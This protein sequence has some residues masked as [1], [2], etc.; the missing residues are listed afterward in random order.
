MIN[1]TQSNVILCYDYL[2]GT[3]IIYIINYL[4]YYVQKGS[5]LHLQIFGIQ[6]LFK[7][8]IHKAMIFK[9]YLHVES[10]T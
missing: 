2:P 3:Y 4:H 7:L 5:H 9:F 8:D 6:S 1:S 10:I